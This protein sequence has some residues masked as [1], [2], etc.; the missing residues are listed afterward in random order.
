MRDRREPG[1]DE[2]KLASIPHFRREKWE[3]SIFHDR[4]DL[5]QTVERNR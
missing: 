2:G 4:E 5:G 3:F 1:K